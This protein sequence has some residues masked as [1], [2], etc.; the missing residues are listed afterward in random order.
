M[1]IRMAIDMPPFSKG[2]I[3]T[4]VEKGKSGFYKI[5]K[6]TCK[7]KFTSSSVPTLIRNGVLEEYRQEQS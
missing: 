4:F 3:C 5:Q 6:G 7:M 1:N 2:E